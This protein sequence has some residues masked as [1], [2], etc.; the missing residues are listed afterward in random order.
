MKVRNPARLCLIEYEI[1]N[2]INF[3]FLALLNTSDATKCDETT[4]LMSKSYIE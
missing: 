3:D 1:R 2:G 4:G